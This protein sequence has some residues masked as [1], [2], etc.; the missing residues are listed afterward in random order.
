ML[1]R[2]ATPWWRHRLLTPAPPPHG[3]PPQ[4]QPAGNRPGV[5]ASAEPG[6]WHLSPQAATDT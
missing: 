3:P 5:L 6:R 2:E 4:P 1:C